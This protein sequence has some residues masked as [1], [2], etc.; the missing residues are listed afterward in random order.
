MLGQQLDEQLQRAERHGDQHGARPV[1]PHLAFVFDMTQMWQET[2]DEKQRQQ[3]D[4]QIHIENRAPA[5]ILREET[6]ERR[7]DRVGNTERRTHQHLP[8]QAHD[9]VGKQIGNTGERGA[10]QHAAADALQTAREH[11]EQHIVGRAAQHRGAREHDDRRDHKRLAPVVIAEPA[12]NR[13][14]NHRGQQIGRGDPRVQLETLEFGDDGGQG[15]ADHGLVER[16]QHR[17]EGDAEHR[18]QRFTER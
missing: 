8:A 17:D 12:E 10:D 5:V 14:G 3:T 4:G 18:Q 7:P 1:E 15:G 2:P 6:A 11:E 13:H 9:R 16:D